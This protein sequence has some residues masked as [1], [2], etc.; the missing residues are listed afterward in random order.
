VSVHWLFFATHGFSLQAGFLKAATEIF[1]DTTKD[2]GSRQL[3]GL[4]LKNQFSA[5]VHKFGDSS[6]QLLN[7]RRLAFW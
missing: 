3:A 4:L 5:K 6:R 2:D 1:S 7:D